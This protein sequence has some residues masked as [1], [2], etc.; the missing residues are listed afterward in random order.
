[1]RC[2]GDAD[3]RGALDRTGIRGRDDIRISA[4]GGIG[5]KCEDMV[6]AMRLAEGHARH[7]G[8]SKALPVL[9]ALAQAVRAARGDRPA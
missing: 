7:A 9:P 8:H 6:D 5:G 3:A 4:Q 2:E 1:M